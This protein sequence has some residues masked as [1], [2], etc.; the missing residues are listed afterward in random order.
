MIMNK[1]SGLRSVGSENEHIN[2]FG[3]VIAPNW[4]FQPGYVFDI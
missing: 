4:T 2:D 1:K 3:N